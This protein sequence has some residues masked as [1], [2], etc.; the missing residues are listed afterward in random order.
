M[1]SLVCP[2]MNAFLLAKFTYFHTFL[3][4]KVP[5]F[6]TSEKTEIVSQP[7]TVCLLSV[8]VTCTVNSVALAQYPG[9]CDCI[10]S[11]RPLLHISPLLLKSEVDLGKDSG[12]VYVLSS[13]YCFGVV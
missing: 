5:H 13:E 10:W 2:E 1:E 6:Q 3:L 11:A 9:C 4:T 8:T 12:T 7:D